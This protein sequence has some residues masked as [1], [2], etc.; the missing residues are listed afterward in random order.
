MS[1]LFPRK[2][3]SNISAKA[4]SEATPTLGL[5]FDPKLL[6]QLK[7][8]LPGTKFFPIFL[9]NVHLFV[10]DEIF[11]GGANNVEN[12]QDELNGLL[13]GGAPEEGGFAPK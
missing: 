2:E 3:V 4:T 6:G 12:I 11:S 1:S 5:P 13:F 7:N 8:F 9:G 10:F